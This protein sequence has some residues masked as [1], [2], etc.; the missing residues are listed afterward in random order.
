MA[1]Q[2]YNTQ[3]YSSA[4]S[5][6][7]SLYNLNQSHLPTL[8]LLGCTS[9]SLGFHHHSIFYNN[10]ILSIDPQFAEAYSNLGTTHRSMAAAAAAATTATLSATN[11]HQENNNNFNPLSYMLGSSSSSSFPPPP[12][13]NLPILSPPLP[14][15]IGKSNIECAEYYYR[16][17]VSIRPKYWDAN[18][19][20]A[21]LLSSQGRW[22]EA[23]DVYEKIEA[24]MEESLSPNERLAYVPA[25]SSL[26]SS[27]NDD[28]GIFGEVECIRS[29]AATERLRSAKLQLLAH[30]TSPIA[31]ATD[32]NLFSVERR[33]DLYFAKGNLF[34]AIGSIESAKME[35]FKGLVVVGLDISFAYNQSTSTVNSSNMLLPV[36]TLTPQQAL[37]IHQQKQGKPPS[38]NPIHHPTTS[39]ILQTLAKMYQDANRIS[40]A[41]S[42]Y[43][44]SL[45][46]FPT[47]NTCN[48][49]GILLAGQRLAESIHWYEFGLILDP[50]HVHLYTNL[51]SALKDS[52]KV[53]E[54]IYCYQRAISLQPDFFIALANLANV[55]KDQGRVEEAIELYRRG[56]RVKPDFVEAF[57]NYA[58]SLLFICDWTDRDTNLEQIKQIVR[59][60]LNEGALTLPKTV[61]TV[62]PFHTFTYSSLD[63]WMVREISR[64][65]ADRVTWNVVTSDWFVGFPQ[66]PRTLMRKIKSRAAAAALGISGGVGCQQSSTSPLSTAPPLSL[67]YPY[68]YPIPPIPAPYIKVGYVSSDFNNHPLAHLMQSVFGM[69]DRSRFKV[70]CYSLSPTDH[71]PYRL[72]IEKES[73]VFIDISNWSIK[74]IVERISLVDQIHI[75]CNLN[76]YTKGGRN[77]IFAA[78]PCP[79]QMAFM[80][81]AGTMGAGPINDSEINLGDGKEMTVGGGGGLVTADTTTAASMTTS[82]SPGDHELDGVASRWIDYIVV[83]E[84]VCPKKLVCGEPLTMEEVERENNRLATTNTTSHLLP[85]GSAGPIYADN[86]KSRIYTEGVIYM[87]QSYFV[88][89]HRQGFRDVEDIEADRITR[90]GFSNNDA[91][92]VGGGM[93]MAPEDVDPEESGLTLDEVFRWRKEEIRRLRMRR[94]VFPMIKED[95]VI[96]ANFNQLYKVGESGLIMWVK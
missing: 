40:L 29:I 65:N 81:Y 4:L 89:D 76:G 5:I 31:T 56:L 94:E 23:I 51:G 67:S 82:S 52:G 62:L 86:D 80:G 39:S 93:D 84:I 75:L 9:Y 70:Y 49:L 41:L 55:Y 10:A 37:Q 43:Y 16:T 28:G 83:D 22:R 21:G 12:P 96:F 18:I 50:G 58:N 74:D 72:K 36:S 95:T 73:D 48:N 60:Q 1:H 33:R 3:D 15:L 24:L 8:L 78:R 11:N 27:S 66:R 85:M 17:A 91:G 20:L 69:H 26:S 77:E 44:I 68:P 38:S 53:N 87:P 32:P 90:M 19:N 79:I 34:Y 6:L 57:C 14:A 42:Y 2:K 64:R 59:K 45:S 61:P 30:A 47:A 7:Q 88:N 54:G 92:G 63:S 71:S 25:P 13:P 46:I 35:Y